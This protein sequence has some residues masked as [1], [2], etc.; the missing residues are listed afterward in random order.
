[1]MPVGK[2]MKYPA[3]NLY[4]ETTR[5]TT[6]PAKNVTIDINGDGVTSVGFTI[7]VPFLSALFIA[8]FTILG[9]LS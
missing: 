9:A 6:F 2:C 5:N 7:R 8:G 1:M 3:E 4:R